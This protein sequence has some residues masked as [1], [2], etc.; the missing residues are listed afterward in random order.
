MPT[1]RFPVL[2]C[3]D[4]AGLRTAV[5][6]DGAASGFAATGAE[7]LTQLR[8]YL[9]WF[10]RQRPNAPAPDFLEPQLATIRVE[11][12]P[13]FRA[14][15]RVFPCEQSLVLRVACVHGRQESGLRVASLPLLGTRFYFHDL[16]LL[17]ELV[18]RYA[19][20]ELEGK[21]PG[22]LARFLPPAEFE[23]TEVNVRV[24]AKE[25]AAVEARLPPT[26]QQ[27]AEP[28][29]DRAVRKQFSKAYER[30]AL[31][32]EVVGKL[33]CE[34][35]NVLLVGEPGVGKSAVLVDAVQQVER[36]AEKKQRLFWL[37]SAGRVIAGMRYLGM[38][39]ERVEKAIGELAELPGV[40]CVDRLLELVR[41]GGF[42]ATDCIAAF[43]IPYL[44]RG[45]LK[46]A[47]EATPA[48]LDACRR[49]LPGFADLFQVVHVP[50]LDRPRA[51][52]ILDRLAGS[53]AQATR[54]TVA[55]GAIDRAYHLFRRFAPYHVFPG[56]AV[57][58]VRQLFE[59][60]QRAKLTSAGPDDVLNLF[61]K[62]TGLP[63]LFLR[64]EITLRRDD[65]L[66]HFRSVIID[67]EEAC[68]AA[69]NL[70]TT[71]K[72]GLNDP[73]RPIGVLLFCGPTGVGK[74]ALA[75]AIARYF[76]GATAESASDRLIRLDMSEYA[77]FD[78]A[79]RL[80]GPQHGEP[81]PLIRKL[82]EQP[83]SVVLFDEIE[84]ASPEV[85]DLLLGVFDEGRLT[86]RFGRATT[87]RGSILLLTSNLGAG[88]QRSLG[89]GAQTGPRYLD[90]ARAFFR[91]EFFNR[92]DGV[93]TFAP[94]GPETIRAITRKELA[95]LNNREGLRRANLKLEVS[96]ALVEFLAK[97]GF[98]ARYGARPLQRT[99]E[100]LITAPLAK[101]LLKHPEVR[102]T[103]LHAELGPAG[104]IEIR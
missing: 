66:A 101:W 87:F 69:A 8:E 23:L 43:L 26:L 36:A 29:G 96:E 56:K 58:F 62:Q 89:F 104:T 39:E 27:I 24:K 49:L 33:S 95:G 9:Q 71:F 67:Q 30:E 81:S 46:M 91:P 78:A 88:K 48:E 6:I 52:A 86:D 59:Q 3:R 40:L 35:A 80:L 84:K 98:D 92:L 50:P 75:R 17:K 13:E 61:I 103:L 83:F 32:T 76:F 18:Q 38:W 5:A 37:T 19:A 2:L 47:G 25:R 1:Y 55:P 100:R 79:D 34:K 21:S 12:R 64:D 65:V 63:E 60:Q 57:A 41:L 97:Q 45:E 14:E 99:I 54:V 74:T 16:E 68:D 94:L 15:E 10:Y 53:L 102:D 28:L 20:V 73:N 44:Q 90:E 72:A 11:A 4:A 70:V 7:A 82:R 22:E 85:F 93:V 51:L 42:D 77:G 31:V